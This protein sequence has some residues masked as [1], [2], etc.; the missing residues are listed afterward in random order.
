MTFNFVFLPIA[1]VAVG[2]FILWL[3]IRRMRSISVRDIS[4]WRRVIERVVLSVVVLA[5]LVVVL[6]T[7]YN[8]IAI[9]YFWAR[10]PA[11]G[12]I[13]DVDG[14]RMHI[15]C[16]GSGSPVLV[17]EAGGQND[18]AI[19]M[20]VQ[21][22]LSKT[23]TVCSYDRAGTGWSDTQPGPRDADHIAAELHQLLEHAGIKDP[24]ILMAH[25]IGG[26]Y[27]RDYVTHYPA[28]VVGIVFV[29]SSTPF[30][31]RNPALV[32]ASPPK[33]AKDKIVDSVLRPWMWNVAVVVGTPRLLGMCGHE[34]T[35]SEHIGKV[36]SEEICRLR[37]SAWD[38]IDEWDASSQETVNSGPF[39]ALPIL[40]LSRDTSKG[41]PNNP[42]QN[43]LDRRH[44]WNQMQEDLKRLSTRSRR[45]I[46]R[47]S[48][49]QI[50]L[51]RADLI[52]KEVPLFIEE[53][54]GSIPPPETE[55]ATVTE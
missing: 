26:L 45:I 25:S 27:A 32:R 14:H 41:L 47:N 46:A 20:G 19:W 31:D 42:L 8:A 22:A 12:R 53:A 35:A 16:T 17:L 13:V 4:T 34:H 2:I 51:D 6:S 10:N 52:E 39:G 21:P 18:A 38:E 55:G 36:Q 48:A 30:Q 23:T 1:I 9:D 37:T 43:E 40:I 50:T 5:A 54:R 3:S 33:T 15:N 49:H 24:F 28:D 29:D 44:A 7:S 11:S